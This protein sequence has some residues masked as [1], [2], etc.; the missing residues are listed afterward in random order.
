MGFSMAMFDSRMVLAPD[1]MVVEIGI[2]TNVLHHSQQYFQ[3]CTHHIYGTV[4]VFAHSISQQ[5]SL[6]TPIIIIDWLLF[7]KLLNEILMNY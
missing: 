4:V 3:T 7:L 5:K 2:H 1:T 6:S